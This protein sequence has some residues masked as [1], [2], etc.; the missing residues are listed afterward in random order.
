MNS[1]AIA[2][3]I[4]SQVIYRFCPTRLISTDE[5]RSNSGCNIVSGDK[6]MEIW[7]N[8]AA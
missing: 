2:V 3:A 7:L 1:M 4:L 5:Q 6:F 8:R